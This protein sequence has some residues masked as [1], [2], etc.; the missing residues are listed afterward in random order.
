VGIIALMA[1]VHKAQFA[2]LKDALCQD[3][4]VYPAKLVLLGVLVAAEDGSADKREKLGIARR[5]LCGPAA[6]LSAP[7]GDQGGWKGGARGL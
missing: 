7:E 3:G 5:L 2:K 1:V 4:V 6:V